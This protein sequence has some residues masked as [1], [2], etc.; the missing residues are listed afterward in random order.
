[1]RNGTRLSG[2]I[3]VLIIAPELAHSDPASAFEVASVKLTSHGRTADGWSYSDVDIPSPG[4]L[5]ATNGSLQELIV[6]AYQVKDYQLSGP[7]WLNSDA[8]CYDIEAKAPPGTPKN[9]MRLMLQTLLAERFKLALHRETRML[10]VYALV[11]AKNGQKMHEAG[12]DQPAGFNSQ[13]GREKVR[14]NSSKASMEDL[15]FRLSRDLDRPVLD[16]TGIKG[17]FRIT[18][19][20][21][22]EGDG[23]SVFSAIQQELG[24]KLES[25]KAPIEVLV[26]EHAERIPTEN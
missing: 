17:S 10:P 25:T 7:D 19:E 14:I 1:M 8:A 20:W 2:V 16:R 13:G 24:L 26:I 9:Q 3:V 11:I 6:F 22:R 4:R 21:A 15:A 5:V 23:P 18:L 12:P